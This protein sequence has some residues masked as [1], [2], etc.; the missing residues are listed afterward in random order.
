M[1][2][3]K[4]TAKKTA[5]LLLQINAIKLQPQEPFTWAS[6]WKSPIY[7]DNRV[8]L[9]Y[10]TIRNYIH[11]EMAK[12]VEILYGKPDAI[13][14]VATG[15]IGIGMLVADYLNVPFAYVR[16]EP[17]KHGRK[18]QIEGHLEPNSN[19]VVIEDLI[20]TGKSSLMAVEALKNSN[21]N[22]KGMLAIFTYGFDIATQN[23]KEEDI[24]LNTLSDY[25]HL[26]EQASDSNYISGEQKETLGNWRKDPSI[27][28]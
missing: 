25:T 27:W 17:K 9:S 22:V 6:G 12:Q 8:T 5:E 16:P 21:M 15:A 10:P 2:L 18:N 23:F 28:G 3:D 1:I 26:L 7:C 24:T 13:V 4:E 11:Q 19:V 20:S 14:G